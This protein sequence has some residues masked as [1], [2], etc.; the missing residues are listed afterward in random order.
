MRKKT[1]VS[2]DIMLTRGK[3][4]LYTIKIDPEEK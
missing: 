1:K 4:N 2:K 3:L